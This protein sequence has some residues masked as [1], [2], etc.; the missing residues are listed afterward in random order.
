MSINWFIIKV[1]NRCN[2]NCTYCYVFNR[3]DN[4]WNKKPPILSAKNI[5]LICLRIAEHC[6]QHNKQKI[7][8]ELHGGEPLL[9]GKKSFE[10]LALTLRKYC[11]PTQIELCLQTN[12]LLL[13]S[14]WIELF[15]KHQTTFSI[16]VDPTPT[17]IASARI[18]KKG[19]D[20][21]P[22]LIKLINSLAHTPEFKATFT[23]ALCVISNKTDPV[24]VVDW[25]YKNNM[26]NFDLLLPDANYSN[27]DPDTST[28][29]VKSFLLKA[30]KRWIG[31]DDPKFRIRIF[32]HLIQKT[33]GAESGLDALGGKI[34][35]MCVIESDSTIHHHDVLKI[36]PN[37][38][39]H[40]LNLLTN[41]IDDFCNNAPDFLDISLPEKC[42]TCRHRDICGGGYL[43]HRF[44]N[45]SFDY[46]SY[47]CDVLYGLIDEIKDSLNHLEHHIPTI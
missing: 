25:F 20:S 28:D 3:G 17:G 33:L 24:F 8:I 22:E 47:Y 38:S 1:A 46:P 41:S 10:E 6:R 37:L 43:P 35:D 42:T 40:S 9:I 27:P 16:S 5:E 32:Q 34:N 39:N 4:S 18:D 2:L 19:N 12:G 11:Y 36:C 29:F 7:V 30:Y 14:K 26:H 23:G 13:D 21:T 15:V 31:I 44:K 45:N